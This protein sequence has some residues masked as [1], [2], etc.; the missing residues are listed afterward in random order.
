MGWYPS[1][2]ITGQSVRKA[3]PPG[4]DELAAEAARNLQADGRKYF[5][6]GQPYG[7]GPVSAKREKHDDPEKQQA[8][9][10][11]EVERL[12][13]VKTLAAARAAQKRAGDEKREAERKHAVPAEIPSSLPGSPAG[14]HIPMPSRPSVMIYRTTSAGPSVAGDRPK[15]EIEHETGHKSPGLGA[16]RTSDLA[17]SP[18]KGR[19]GSYFSHATAKQLNASK[20]DD[21]ELTIAATTTVDDLS[22]EPSLFGQAIDGKPVFACYTLDFGTVVKG[23]V[24]KKTVRIANTSVQPLTFS[25]NKKIFASSGVALTPDKAGKL[26]GHPSY[27]DQPLEVQ[28]T[29]KGEKAKDVTFGDYVF[30]IPIEIR[31]S[32]YVVLKV[33]AFVMVPQLQLL[34]ASPNAPIDFHETIESEDGAFVQRGTTV[35]ET[36]IVTLQLFNPL[37]LPCEW[38]AK[39]DVRRSQ[40]K[41]VFVCKPEKGYLA[42]KKR[43]Q[44]QVMFVPFE[45]GTTHGQLNLKLAQNPKTI[46]VGLAGT[47][48]PIVVD[49]IP[50]VLE[51]PAVLPFAPT[52][53]DFVLRNK[54]SR[55]VEVYALSSDEVHGIEE[56]ILRT[57]DIYDSEGI[58][59]LPPREPG[60]SL[61]DGLLEQY[62]KI[63]EEED[64]VYSEAIE[65]IDRPAKTPDG[66]AVGAEERPETSQASNPLLTPTSQAPLATPGEGA[67]LGPVVVLYGP[68]LSGKSTIAKLLAKEYSC[69]VLRLDE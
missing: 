51:F 22:H 28:L 57:V 30:D 39:T 52:K 19:Q 45:A 55:P 42:P 17:K 27:G 48:V 10:D 53:K 65:R 64:R 9:M 21:G 69:D 12:Y 24:K 59:L 3:Q 2:A 20:T 37:P 33:K 61:D 18:G 43:C 60:S 50:P 8:T 32:G 46:H 66:E 26:A 58:G 11:E 13:V 41:N 35:G 29:T 49:V 62:Y 5:L 34:N 25:V 6:R 1:V 4:Y 54:S 47:G 23:D 44:L 7:S 40:P 15:E 38:T 36:R 14:L 56:E 31:G 68:T 63:L 16:R 67:A